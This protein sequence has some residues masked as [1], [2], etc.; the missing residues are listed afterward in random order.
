MNGF[1][2]LPIKG[3]KREIKMQ[4]KGRKRNK[5][6]GKKPN[7][8]KKGLGPHPNHLRCI[9]PRGWKGPLLNMGL[10]LLSDDELLHLHSRDEVLKC[11]SHNVKRM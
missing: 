1:Y 9:R 3:M 7:P 10:L 5:P 11:C 4:A 8:P 2:G 6:K